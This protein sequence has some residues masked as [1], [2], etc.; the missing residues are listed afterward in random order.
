MREIFPAASTAIIRKARGGE[1]ARRRETRRS[2]ICHA[3]G[4]RVH[5]NNWNERANGHVGGASRMG[6]IEVL[7][8]ILR[9]YR[10]QRCS[11]IL[12]SFRW[13]GLLLHN[14]INTPVLATSRS[15]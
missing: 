13:L 5:L 3:T 2:L 11:I 8:R 10:D 9:E 12:I 15:L 7:Q 4:A 14:S 1:T 6:S